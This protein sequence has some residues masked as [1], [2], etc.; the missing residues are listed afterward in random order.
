M[1][2]HGVFEIHPLGWPRNSMRRAGDSFSASYVPSG[3]NSSHSCWFFLKKLLLNWVSSND[4]LPLPL[5]LPLKLLLL[6]KIQSVLQ[7]PQSKASFTR[8]LPPSLLISC[9]SILSLLEDWNDYFRVSKRQ[10]AV[11]RRNCSKWAIKGDTIPLP[12]TPC[13]HIP[14][15][16]LSPHTLNTAVALSSS[17]LQSTQF[18]PVSCLVFLGSHHLQVRSQLH[19][20][21]LWTLHN[22]AK[23]T[24]G[25][26]STWNQ[27]IPQS[28]GPMS[29]HPVFL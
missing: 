14:I 3:I 1:Y 21:S 22:L 11:G 18:G 7:R 10:T 13:T 9:S 6:I 17:W 24:S 28:P 26:F 5:F 15:L 20:M 25:C 4:T 16:T 29:L 19:S 8:S 12:S 2:Y 23:L 27:L